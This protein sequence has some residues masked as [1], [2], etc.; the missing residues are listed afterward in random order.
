MYNHL[1]TAIRIIRLQPFVRDYCLSETNYKNCA[2]FKIK[3]Q[4]SEAPDNLLPD[5]AKLKD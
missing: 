2:R 4:G 3:S 5:G 1:T